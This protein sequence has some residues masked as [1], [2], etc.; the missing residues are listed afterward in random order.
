MRKE[1]V[2]LLGMLCVSSCSVFG[3]V[4]TGADNTYVINSVPSVA[5]RCSHHLNLMVG[6]VETNPLYNTTQM[7][8]TDKRFELS[9]FAK[10]RWAE[11][12]GQMLQPLII[13]TLQN[14]HFFHAV[15]SYPAIGVYDYALSVQ[16]L[17]LQQK[18]VGDSSYISL[19]VHVQLSKAIDNHVVASK[20]ISI[21]EAAPENTPY[22]GVIAANRATSAMLSELVR[23][24]LQKI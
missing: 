23:F 1:I 20:D 24:C 7:A 5:K 2:I 22:G 3:P 6:A 4:S 18:F 8:Y 11:T 15:N 12:P 10:N 13:Q 21:T 17:E 19:K 14:T 16:L 9:Y